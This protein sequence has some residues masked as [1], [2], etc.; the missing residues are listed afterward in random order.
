MGGGGMCVGFIT[1]ESCGGPGSRIEGVA[2]RVT[3]HQ[4]RNTV[5]GVLRMARDWMDGTGWG[6]FLNG[7]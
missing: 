6:G 1:E 7:L 3:A 5:T 4:V 2:A